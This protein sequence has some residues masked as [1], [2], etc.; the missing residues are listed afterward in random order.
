M[1]E[2]RPGLCSCGSGQESY[3]LYDGYGIE[4]C[5]A[6]EKCERAKMSGFRPDVMSRYA[7]DEE[8]EPS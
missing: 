1:T 5:K 8:I 6:C 4:L 7:C 3:W 2:W